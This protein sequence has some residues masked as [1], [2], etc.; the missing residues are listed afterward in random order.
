VRSAP[1]RP[2]TPAPARGLLSF[3]A[4]PV[5]TAVSHLPQAPFSGLLCCGLPPVRGTSAQRDRL[6]PEREPARAAPGPLPPRSLPLRCGQPALTD[7]VGY[8]VPRG[9]LFVSHIIAPG[10]PRCGYAAR[11]IAT[12]P[13]DKPVL[14]PDLCKRWGRSDHPPFGGQIFSRN[15]RFE[16]VV[17]RGSDKVL[18]QRRRDPADRPEVSSDQ[19]AD[20][21][22]LVEHHLA[23]VRVAGS[24]PVVRSV[25]RLGASLAPRETA[26]RPSAKL[27]PMAEWPSGLGK[28]LQSPVH[29]FDSRLRLRVFDELRS[30]SSSL[31]S[32]GGTTP[33]PPMRAT[34]AT[35]CVL[36]AGSGNF[37][38]GSRGPDGGPSNPVLCRW[39]V[40]QP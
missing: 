24:N 5:T 18:T 13:G 12:M 9:G 23:K 39:A 25:A 28:G 17:A 26:R 27:A 10:C 16:L 33:G 7:D 29:G 1:Q 22:Q 20:V 2:D 34:P 3:L 15:P 35:C 4:V 21:A 8:K 32:P 31:L 30:S 37:P 6:A 40:H 38:W 14:P 19:N 36:S 11:V